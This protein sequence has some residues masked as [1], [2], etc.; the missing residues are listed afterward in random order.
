MV[1]KNPSLPTQNESRVRALQQFTQPLTSVQLARRLEVSLSQASRLVRSLAKHGL[2]KCL[3]P[4]SRQNRLYWLTDKGRDA[5]LSGGPNKALEA[6]VH[7]F[8]EINWPQYGW[9]CNRHRESVI[10]ALTRPLP[11]PRIK[12]TALQKNPD[13]RMSNGNCRE[14]VRDMRRRGIVRPVELP[15][16]PH[17]AYQLTDES[18]HYQRLLQQADWSVRR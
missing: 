2:L 12:R 13:L 15:G 14:V 9:T 17:P 16:Q 18:L 10:K 6:I 8:P 4:Q 1:T 11:P 3:N 7:D 5:Q